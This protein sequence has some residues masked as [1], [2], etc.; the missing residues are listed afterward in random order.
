MNNLDFRDMIILLALDSNARTS[1][2]QLSKI[3]RLSKSAVSQRIARLEQEKYIEGYYTIID[4]SRLGLLSFRVYLK[5]YKTSPKKELEIMNFLTKEKKVWWLGQ[6]HGAWDVGFIV[7]V[8][9]LYDFRNFWL[10]FFTRFRPNIGK[11]QISPYTKLRHYSLSYLSKE[12]K[13]AKKAGIVGEGPLIKL[14]EVDEKILKIVSVNAR[15]TIVELSEKT[16]LSPAIVKYRLKQLLRKGI[17]QS[18]RAKIN[19]AKL[20]Y[21]LYKV[22]FYLDDLEKLGEL[23]SFA[24]N[25]PNLVYIDETIGGGDFEAE[26]HLK[27]EQEM[28]AVLKKFKEKF[29]EAIREVEYIV[30]SKELKYAYFPQ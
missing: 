23:E 6:L 12:P 11:H 5:F 13:L 19:V 18:F 16:G 1:L 21:S 20:G 8:K 30:Y 7:G 15:K 22:E 10:D 28:K 3:T 2:S 9:D 25:Q 29:F 24:E 26:F 14:D 17:I 4:S 27:S